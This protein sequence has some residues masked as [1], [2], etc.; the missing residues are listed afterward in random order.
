M[1]RKWMLHVG[2][3]ILLPK[4]SWLRSYYWTSD[5]KIIL[6]TALLILLSLYWLVWKWKKVKSLSRVWLFVTLWTVAYQAHQS[7]GFSRQEYWSGLSFPSPRDLPEPAIKWGS[8][9]LQTDALPS[10]P[11]GKSLKNV[12]TLINQLKDSQ[13]KNK[14]TCT[15][16]SQ[17]LSKWP[18]NI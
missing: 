12:R 17:N 3:R 16:A 11:P 9:A 2:F 1:W 13:L 6:T 7:M 18:I 5:S 15:G 8:P 10:E 14:K 4:Y